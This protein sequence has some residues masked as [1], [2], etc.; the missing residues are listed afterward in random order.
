VDTDKSLNEVPTVF[1]FC[2]LKL[3]YLKKNYKVGEKLSDAFFQ[4]ITPS[5][6]S[7][8]FYEDIYVSFLSNDEQ[9]K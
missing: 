6:P 3:V 7:L 9:I 2:A 8:I 5:V 4:I 1:F